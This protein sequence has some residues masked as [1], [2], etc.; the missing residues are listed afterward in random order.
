MKNSEPFEIMHPINAYIK[1]YIGLTVDAFANQTGFPQSTLAT[2]VSRKR[3]VHKLP[4]NF[5]FMLSQYKKSSMDEVY[6]QLLNLQLEY[7]HFLKAYDQSSEALKQQKEIF[8]EGKKLFNTFIK[9]NQKQ[10]LINTIDE[11]QLALQQK[12]KEGVILSILALY[13]KGNLSLPSF[14]STFLSKRDD[15]LYIVPLWIESMLKQ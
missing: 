8:M 12:D 3:P 11:I 6:Q 2:W 10:V 7:D 15:Y 13:S 1:K 9:K 14:M 4:V 5:I